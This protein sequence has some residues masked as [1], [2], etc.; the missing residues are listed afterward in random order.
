NWRATTLASC[1][2]STAT[3]QL[4]C[5][6]TAGSHSCA[7][8]GLPV[9]RRATILSRTWIPRY[10]RSSASTMRHRP[11]ILAFLGLATAHPT[12]CSP[13]SRGSSCRTDRAAVRSPPTRKWARGGSIFPTCEMCTSDATL[14]GALRSRTPCFLQPWTRSALQAARYCSQQLRQCLCR[15]HGTWTSTWFADRAAPAVYLPPS[16]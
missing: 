5:R 10:W 8:C 3:T 16:T 9:E 2:G 14:T 7:A 13:R 12:S 11:L 6:R 1:A 4:R 15:L